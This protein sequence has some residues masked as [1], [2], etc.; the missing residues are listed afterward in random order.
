MLKG[1]KKHPRGKGGSLAEAGAEGFGGYYREL[2]AALGAVRGVV[3]KAN[4]IMDCINR[5][6][7]PK[8]K[9]VVLLLYGLILSLYRELLGANQTHSTAG[10]ITLS[11]ETYCCPGP[12][13][14]HRTAWMMIPAFPMKEMEQEVEAFSFITFFALRYNAALC[15]DSI[16]GARRKPAGRPDHRGVPLCSG[17]KHSWEEQST[18]WGSLGFST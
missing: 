1:Q 13:A 10:L 11:S 17:R 6:S 3:R 2:L 12:G 5:G 9:D 4:G 16:P 14:V 8:S 18:N 7:N 15:H